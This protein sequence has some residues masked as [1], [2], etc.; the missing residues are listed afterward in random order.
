MGRPASQCLG[1]TFPCTMALPFSYTLPS[2]G[3]TMRLTS[4]FC[5]LGSSFIPL[6]GSPVG[7]M[8]EATLVPQGHLGTSLFLLP[9]A[10]PI[11]ILR[12]ALHPFKERSTDMCNVVANS[13]I[14]NFSPSIQAH[15]ITQEM[16]GI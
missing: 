3:F 14:W 12:P 13:I 16:R 2:P 1:C 10:S 11:F 4:R 6:L 8:G 7:T 9:L 5:R 15:C